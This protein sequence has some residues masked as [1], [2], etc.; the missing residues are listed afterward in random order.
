MPRAKFYI[1]NFDQDRASDI[2]NIRKWISTITLA[3][4]DE[5]I[6]HHFLACVEISRLSTSKWKSVFLT[7]VVAVLNI[8]SLEN[9]FHVI[10]VTS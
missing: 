2:Y 5:Y 6:E 9:I 4:T 3:G 10:I 7:S 8:I 1:Y